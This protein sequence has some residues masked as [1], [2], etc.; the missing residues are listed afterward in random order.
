MVSTHKYW[1]KGDNLVKMVVAAML[2]Q[3]EKLVLIPDSATD[4]LWDLEQTLEA[5][6]T[7]SSLWCMVRAAILSLM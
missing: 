5:W 7:R 4:F 2:Q 6:S 1:G 3:L